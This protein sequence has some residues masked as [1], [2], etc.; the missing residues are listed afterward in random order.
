MYGRGTSGALTA[1]NKEQLGNSDLKVLSN[2]SALVEAVLALNDAEGISPETPIVEDPI[3]AEVV[4]EV[5][6]AEAE[7]EVTDVRTYVSK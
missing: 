1:Y 2:V 3:V 6:V 5:E 7:P 4:P